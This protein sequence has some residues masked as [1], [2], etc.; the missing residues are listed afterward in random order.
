MAEEVAARFRAA[1]AD[2]VERFPAADLDYG[3]ASLA[4][5]DGVAERAYGSRDFPG[6]ELG[7][8]DADSRLLTGLSR[9]A[10]GYL[11][12]VLCRHLGGEW[13]DDDGPAV[14]AEGDG[15]AVRVDPVAVA[16]DAFRGTDSFADTFETLDRRLS[17]ADD[18][19]DPVI[20]RLAAR[21][22]A[23][24]AA[25]DATGADAGAVA[26]AHAAA[27]AALADDWPG[28]DLD[29]SVASLAHLDAL[30]AREFDR[31]GG[32]REYD[33]GPLTLPPDAQLSIPTDG[34]VE[35]FG[36]Y[37]AAVL[38][39]HHDAA[40]RVEGGDATLVVDGPT[41]TVELDPG[42][43]A[44]ACFAGESSFVDAYARVAADAGLD[45]PL[46]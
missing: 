29:R 37:L 4:R 12:E 28:Y 20:D 7:G 18:D 44:V 19:A 5:L 22:A 46:G 21:A 35:R 11:G 30:V 16:A 17:P 32:H 45:P 34:S 26:E 42:T 2:L 27:A 13:R 8:E 41:D 38:R 31:S 6:A 40:W 1:A 15:R 9:E 33:G 39:E 25:E 36:G 14:V 23:E 3:P 10:G 43:V 24:T